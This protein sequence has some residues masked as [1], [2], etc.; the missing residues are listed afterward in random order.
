MTVKE[1]VN[2]SNSMVRLRRLGSFYQSI[3][4]GLNAMNN[5]T[6]SLE[7]MMPSYCM[8]IAGTHNRYGRDMEFTHKSVVL[9]T[10]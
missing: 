8:D 4:L 7:A 10:V 2:N 9:D 1:V 3:I 6:N 5:K